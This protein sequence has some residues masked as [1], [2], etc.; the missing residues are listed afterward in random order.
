MTA[1]S[2][3]G[4]GVGEILLVALNARYRHTSLGL[5]YLQANLGELAAR[6]RLIEFD[7]ER[8]PEEMAEL[9]LADSPRIVAISVQIW[10]VA[11]VQPLVALLK[12]LAPGVVVVLGGPEVS[13]EL[14]D[15]PLA[16]LADFIVVGEGERAFARLCGSLLTGVWPPER[17][18]PAAP[19]ELAGLL[20]PYDLYDARD[21]RERVIYVES[22]RGC[23]FGC[24]FCLSALERRV[25]LFPLEPFLAAMARLF[26]RG[27]RRFKF[28]DRTFNLGLDR[29]LTILDFFL[30]RLSPGLFL[31]FEM[32]ADRLPEALLERLARFPEGVVQLELGIQSLDPEV[33][34]RIG[35]PRDTGLTLENLRRLLSGTRVHLHTDLIIGL[36]G[37]GLEGI[38]AGFDRLWGIG[39]QEIQVGILKRLKGTPLTAMTEEFALLFDPSPPFALLRHDRLDFATLRRLKRFARFWSLVGNSG[40]FR[41][42]LPWLLGDSPFRR[43]LALSDW[44]HARVGRTHAIA[45]PRLVALIREGAGEVLGLEGGEFAR[46]LAHDAAMP[47]GGGGGE[48]GEGPPSRQRRHRR[49]PGMGGARLAEEGLAKPG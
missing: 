27:A 2:S 17:I 8:T 49:G 4:G 26:E 23:P 48:G 10:N 29:A 22:S 11:L 38:A 1:I 39:V 12:L 46:L 42:S 37:E 34:A 19:P 24:A 47:G 36:P 14:E 31:H 21:L 20:L 28:V 45:L 35:R 6:S 3:G 13:H 40:R 44:I 43:F 30:E 15:Q 41:R 18:L 9:L 32:V 5:R 16:R 25:R 7:L 33:L